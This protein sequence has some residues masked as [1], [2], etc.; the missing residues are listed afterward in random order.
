MLGAGSCGSAGQNLAA[1][2][3]EAAELCGVLIVDVLAL[4][5]AE[6]ANLPALA[7]LTLI[8]IESQGFFLLKFIFPRRENVF[9]IRAARYLR[10]HATVWHVILSASAILTPQWR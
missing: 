10:A 2:G 6:L 5:D 1:L 8:T 4:I 9:R 7:V 3:H